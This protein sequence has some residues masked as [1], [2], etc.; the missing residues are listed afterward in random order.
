[1]MKICALMS[2]ACVISIHASQVSTTAQV[3]TA[4]AV[5]VSA[6]KME[7]EVLLSRNLEQKRDKKIEFKGQKK[8]GLP[9]AK[10]VFNFVAPSSIE[11]VTEPLAPAHKNNPTFSAAFILD[12]G[13]LVQQQKNDDDA[14]K[15]DDG[16]KK[17]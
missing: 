11:K 13:Q 3:K 8:I 6:N 2:C 1:M 7:K 12:N 4:L 9:G 14:E 17:Q 16:N 5:C 10:K 15:Q